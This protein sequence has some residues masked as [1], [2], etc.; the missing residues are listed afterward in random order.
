M[1]DTASLPPPMAASPELN[2]V[3]RG[4][5][6][7]DPAHTRV[8]FSVSHFGISTYY[9]EFLRPCGALDL[10]SEQLGAGALAV[11]VPVANVSTSSSVLDTE[12]RSRDWLDSE[13]FPD[14]TFTSS[15]PLS[16]AHRRFLVSGKLSLHGV[17]REI[18]LDAT[19]VGAGINPVKQ[20]YTIGFDIRGTLRRSD[21]G[22]MAALPQIGE[23]IALIISAAFELQTP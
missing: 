17:T 4:S 18:T 16:L 3:R 9:G 20:V 5:Y 19:F 1:T 8:L 11:S 22:V 10:A 2:A 7:L 23:D 21:Y 13:R 14:M 12:L 6:L 15:A